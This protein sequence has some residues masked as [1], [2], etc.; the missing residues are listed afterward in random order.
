MILRESM[1]IA[2]VGLVIG[3]ASSLAMSR[4]LTSFLFQVRATDPMTYGSIAL[5][6]LV[7]AS[8][9]AFGPARRA[10]KVDPLTAL[11]D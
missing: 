4:A 1:G 10:T 5:L 3:L 7:V 11:R 9:A 8:L 6:L 2:G